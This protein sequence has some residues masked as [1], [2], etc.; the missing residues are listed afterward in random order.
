[1]FLFQA[2]P[3]DRAGFKKPVC[4]SHYKDLMRRVKSE[5]IKAIAIS[6]LS[7]KEG[8]LLEKEIQVVLNEVEIG[9]FS[10]SSQCSTIPV[11]ARYF[12][13]GEA[14]TMPLGDNLTPVDI[15]TVVSSIY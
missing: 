9:S 3:F 6:I 1:M 4:I 7:V 13:R 10:V 8:C 12:S 15:L 11:S 14:M 2:V 5:H